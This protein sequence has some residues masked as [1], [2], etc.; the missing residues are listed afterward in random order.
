MAPICLLEGFLL[1]TPSPNWIRGSAAVVL[2]LTIL[3]YFR[4]YMRRL[5]LSETAV[6]WRSLLNSYSI[7]WHEVCTVG[8][9]VPGGGLGATEYLYISKRKEPPAGKWQID[10][11][12]FQVQN[13]P[14]LLEAIE[15]IRNKKSEQT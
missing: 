13:R 12:T 7:S 2:A 3:G 8:T 1:A 6:E 5:V 9:Y 4:G 10:A 15:W 11:S 14:G